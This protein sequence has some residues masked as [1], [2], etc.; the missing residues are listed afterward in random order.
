V[1]A[2]ALCLAALAAPALARP[3][4]PV[5]YNG[6]LPP[7][8]GNSGPSAMPIYVTVSGDHMTDYRS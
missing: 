8:V 1:V 2:A 3:T 7:G 5:T 6:T 4:R